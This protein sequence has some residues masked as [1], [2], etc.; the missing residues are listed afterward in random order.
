M[1]DS[2]VALVTG[3]KSVTFVQSVDEESE[4]S[5]RSILHQNYA[6]DRSAIVESESISQ[7]HTFGR[8]VIAESESWRSK[9]G[10]V[11]LPQQVPPI[12]KS[13]VIQ[14]INC[15]VVYHVRRRKFYHIEPRF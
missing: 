13:K 12:L 14:H 11:G 4:S 10:S 15:H 6:F 1:D 5:V 3:H 9:S 8:S 2:A 7:S